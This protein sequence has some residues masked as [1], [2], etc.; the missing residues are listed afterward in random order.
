MWKKTVF[1]YAITAVECVYKIS[2]SFTKV[3]R[4]YT[5]T[6][7]EQ[8]NFISKEKKMCRLTSGVLELK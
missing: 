6:N 1:H 2:S 4:Q 5:N 7:T 8:S 3:L